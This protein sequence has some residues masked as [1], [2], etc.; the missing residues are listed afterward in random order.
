MVRLS[1][2]TRTTALTVGLLAVA[3]AS[4]AQYSDTNPNLGSN[5]V[6]Q[7]P[8]SS[9]AWANQLVTVDGPSGSAKATLPIAL[10]TARGSVQPHLSLNYLSDSGEG[11]A[12]AGWRL[13]LPSIERRGPSGG[14]VPTYQDQSPTD[15]APGGGVVDPRWDNYDR[16]VYNDQPLVPICSMRGTT[17]AGAPNETLPTLPSTATPGFWT[18]YR[19]E[20]NDGS[21]MR[22]FLSADRHTWVVQVPH[23]DETLEFGNPLDGQVMGVPFDFGD[24]LLDVYRWHLS[25]QYDNQRA[26]GVPT[27]PIVYLWSNGLLTDIFDTPAVTDAPTSFNPNDFAHHVHIWTYNTDHPSYAP[28]WRRVPDQVI[29]HID[30]SS[31]DIAL[32]QR[33]GGGAGGT[34][35][36]RSLVRRYNLV[37]TNN[38]TSGSSTTRSTA[39]GTHSRSTASSSRGAA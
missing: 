5:G 28:A 30:V 34:P 4:S 7:S 31:A 14:P 11:E 3:T 13:S 24:P 17:C 38:P 2:F 36:T 16:F 8:S 6:G 26:S 21:A 33:A 27:N 37:Y 25:R 22:F 32:A 39:T 19:L 35:G 10:P 15:P 1:R 20:V 23:S 18:Y 29:S 9:L 12:G